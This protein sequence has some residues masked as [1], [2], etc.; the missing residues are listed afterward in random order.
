M[1]KYLIILE[2]LTILI[3][4]VMVFLKYHDVKNHV[5]LVKFKKRTTNKCY[6]CGKQILSTDKCL[7]IKTAN[8]KSSLYC[9]SCGNEV[10]TVISKTLRKN[11]KD[12]RQTNNKKRK[13]KFEFMQ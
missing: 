3:I 13:N 9:L 8:L 1:T 5:L 2:L 11:L 6:N 4:A 10:I 12:I 7:F